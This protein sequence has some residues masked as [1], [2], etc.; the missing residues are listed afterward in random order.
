M[1]WRKTL[2]KRRGSKACVQINV[3]SRI[4][5]RVLKEHR[6]LSKSTSHTLHNTSYIIA[7]RTLSADAD[8]SRFFK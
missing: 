1:V 8:N 6:E 5:A 4:N 2:T 7:T 3:W